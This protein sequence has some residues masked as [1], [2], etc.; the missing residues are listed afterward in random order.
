MYIFK[1]GVV[2]AGTMG[3]EIAQVISFSGLPVALVDVDRSALDRGMERIKGIY[4]RRV[5]RGKMDRRTMAERMDLISV[6]TDHGALADAD[7][8]IEA[9]PEELDLKREA[10]RMLDGLC[11]P[12]A[13]LASNT[14]ALSVSE[15]GAASGRP[16]KLVG[17][18]FFFP[19]HIMKLVEV[20]PGLETSQDTVD[21]TVGFAE[22]LRKIPV[23]VQ[24][25]P[26]FVVNRLLLPFL[27]EATYCLQEEAATAGEIDDAI[28]GFGMPMGPFT[29]ADA[30][31]LDVAWS[32]AQTLYEAYGERMAPA[33][34]LRRLVE[35]GR[36]GEKS[37]AGFYGYAGELEEPLEEMI[38]A[39]QEETGIAGTEFKLERCLYPMVNE[40]SRC[41]QERIAEASD[42]DLAMIYGTGMR[43]GEEP[44]GPLRMAD[45]IG[46][47]QILGELEELEA[48]HGP[49]FRPSRLL[50]LK[51]RA[52]HLGTKTGR[53][54]LE[55][56]GGD[57]GQDG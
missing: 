11:S 41:V 26:G 9:I 18:H 8:V 30:L 56:P 57:R 12:T 20:V 50:R 54:F 55:H 36:T 35:A 29:L 3:A 7:I 22:S 52:G 19:A 39:V 17:M 53:G 21:T 14:S 28:V 40:A 34:L 42:I 51:V 27:N 47:D 48:R 44:M 33:L 15:L 24:E 32:V 23:V 2:G 25:C 37:G 38:Q 43:R 45:E 46:L 1:A 13:L 10:F 31:G 4:Q 6:G 16:E 5:D 49:R